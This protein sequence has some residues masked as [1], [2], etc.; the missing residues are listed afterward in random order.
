LRDIE[1]LKKFH[2]N[3]AVLDESQTIKNPVSHR[4]KAACLINARNKIALTGT[5]IENSTFDLF[6]QM[7]FANLGFFGGAHKFR[8]DYSIPIDKDGDEVIAGELNKLI[9]PFVLRRTKEKVASEL[10]DKT[11]NIIFCEMENGQRR[12]YDA[13][14]NEYRNRLLNKIEKDGIEKSKMMV[15]E[16]LIRLR[17]ICDSP[18]LLNSEEVTETQSVKI[19]E[20]VRHITEK[21]GR[22]KILIFS[23][24]IKMLELIQNEL[25]KINIEYEYLDGQSSSK[26]REQSVNNFQENENLRV[27]LISLK[28]G[29]TGLNL[30]AADYVYI[31]DP[32]WNPAVENQAIDRCHR[33]GQDKKVFAYRMICKDTVEEKI[34]ALQDKKKKIAGD[35]IQ[36]D[37][38][39]LK[40]LNKK[41]INELFS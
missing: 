29:G 1:V 37:E 8:E 22:H 14:R 27:F 32:W 17:Q 35:I 38:S 30:T 28:A 21:T 39:I 41:D 16:A 10:P 34:I 3:Y 9:N 31:V 6:A 33:I 4:F 11:E 18:V 36:T 25:T 5:P 2:F 7:S 13:Y 24:F 26:Q 20:I 23:Q 12:V 19:K 40:K 15:L